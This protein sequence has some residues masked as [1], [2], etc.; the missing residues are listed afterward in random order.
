MHYGVCLCS[1][2]RCIDMALS[3]LL[4]QVRAVHLPCQFVL[5]AQHQT[6]LISRRQW[7]SR[8]GQ[9]MLIAEHGTALRIASNLMKHNDIGAIKAQRRTAHPRGCMDCDEIV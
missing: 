2:H 9:R 1:M 8:H 4:L 3:A 7:S 6:T 5:M